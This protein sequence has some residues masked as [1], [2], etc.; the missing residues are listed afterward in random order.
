VAVIRARGGL[1]IGD[2]DGVLPSSDQ[3]CER[4][5][6]YAGGMYNLGGLLEQRGEVEEA[7]RWYREAADLS[8]RDGL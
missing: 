8:N 5:I 3:T 7:E 2:S 1:G 4:N 6:G